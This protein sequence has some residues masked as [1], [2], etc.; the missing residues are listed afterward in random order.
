VPETSRVTTWM[1]CLVRQHIDRAFNRF[2]ITSGTSKRINVIL[3]KPVYSLSAMN[4]LRELSIGLA[5]HQELPNV[6]MSFSINPNEL[7]A[8][9]DFEPA[10]VLADYVERV[11]E[12]IDA[13]VN[14]Y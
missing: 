11:P 12:D 9:N 7:H 6:L 4:L 8:K 13:R 2:G 3:N 14:S 5:S 1:T 10:S